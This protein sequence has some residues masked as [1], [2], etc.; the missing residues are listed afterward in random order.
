MKKF[1]V[2]VIGEI[3]ADLIL[4]GNVE[5][6]FGQVEK[7]ISNAHLVI[8]SSS[9]IFACGA[10]RLGLKTAFIGKVGNDI[11]GDFMIQSMK[12]HGIDVSGVIIDNEI[13]TGLSVILTRES[14][15][16]ILTFPGSIS[17]LLI[18]EI[19]F[20][21]IS[22][23]RHLHLGS[24]FLLDSLRPDIAGL[25][26]RVKESGLT[27]S[28]DTNYDPS[29]KWDGGLDEALNSV[30]I[31]LPNDSE[32][33]AITAENNILGAVDKLSKRIPIVVV[34]LGKD[35]AIV[36]EQGAEIIRQAAFPVAVADT[37]GAGDSF[38]AG[39]IYGFLNQ[40]ELSD[41]LRL[42]VACGSLSTR[43]AGGTNAQPGIQEVLEFMNG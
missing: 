32:I 8:G 39:F 41:S 4:S 11:F 13:R 14:D 30:D 7:V 28:L 37:V 40:W 6:V 23:S 34:K 15:R 1:D 17:E 42:S 2:I 33:K 38:D 27:I 36:K 22:K 20:S 31:F 5:P 3:N 43:K 19:D 18:N 25:F 12:K 16:A 35:G 24:F 10:A 26:K 21:L 29:E 9:V